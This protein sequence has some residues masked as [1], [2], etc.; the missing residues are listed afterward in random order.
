MA[1]CYSKLYRG[2]AVLWHKVGEKGNDLSCL[3]IDGVIQYCKLL[4]GCQTA[5]FMMW[6]FSSPFQQELW[7][8]GERITRG[9]SRSTRSFPW[10]SP[11]YVTPTPKPFL[12]CWY[13]RQN[14]LKWDVITLNMLLHLER[15]MWSI[16][17]VELSSWHWDCFSFNRKSGRHRVHWGDAGGSSHQ[18]WCA[19]LWLSG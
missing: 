7:R 9:T 4:N 18:I 15:L 1:G 12:W 2:A 14:D 11:A 5:E 17:A 8:R 13:D 10:D 6:A 16:D 19:V 3:L